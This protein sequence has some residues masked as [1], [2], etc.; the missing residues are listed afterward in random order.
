MPASANL[1]VLRGTGAH[2]R[3]VQMH[4]IYR[5]DA[6]RWGYSYPLHHRPPGKSMKCVQV[7]NVYINI[8][9]AWTLAVTSVIIAC[10]VHVGNCM[11]SYSCIFLD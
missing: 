11:A 7:Y 9:M 6:V 8:T 2:H 5:G 4:H 10:N 3:Q 1:G